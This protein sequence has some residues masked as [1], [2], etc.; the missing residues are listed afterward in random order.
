M[1]WPTL[2]FAA[3]D[4]ILMGLGHR[5]VVGQGDQIDGDAAPAFAQAVGDQPCQE[6]IDLAFEH[7]E[8]AELISQCAQH[9]GARRGAFKLVAGLMDRE[10]RGCGTDQHPPQVATLDGA[11]HVQ[12]QGSQGI[13]GELVPILAL[14]GILRIRRY[15]DSPMRLR[16][17]V[18]SSRYRRVPYVFKR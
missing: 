10:V 2:R 7:L 9:C 8:I 11:G 4:S 12:G 1:G 3:T 5:S 16:G 18:S 17:L 14:P 13:D 15:R 6:S